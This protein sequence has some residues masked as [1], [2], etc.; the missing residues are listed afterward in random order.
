[1]AHRRPSGERWMTGVVA[2][3]A[4]AIAFSLSNIATAGGIHGTGLRAGTGIMLVAGTLVAA[5]AA[6]LIDG[7]AVLGS[8]SRAGVLF[9]AA[10]GIVHF[11]GGWALINACIRRI[12]ASR[13]SAIT[14]VTPLVAAVLAIVAL[15]EGLDVPIGL[16][17]AGIVA[18][19]YFIATS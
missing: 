2:A 3:I 13:A 6:I 12:G 10:A 1:M 4:A 14:G 18:G 19:T 16:G 5:V 8:A 17:M 11:V 9:F 15:H 7:V